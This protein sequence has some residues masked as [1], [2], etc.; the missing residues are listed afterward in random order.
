V[1]AADRIAIRI[2]PLFRHENSIA[3]CAAFAQL[4]L[5]V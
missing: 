5:D 4:G 1:P 2:D 3:Y